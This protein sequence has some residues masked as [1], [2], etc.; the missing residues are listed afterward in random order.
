MSAI[1]KCHDYMVVPPHPFQ[2]GAV[3]AMSLPDSYYRTPGILPE[4]RDFC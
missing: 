4:R 3:V 2:M 1:R